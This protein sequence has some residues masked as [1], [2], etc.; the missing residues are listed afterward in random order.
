[1]SDRSGYIT[2]FTNSGAYIKDQDNNYITMP[3]KTYKQV[4]FNNIK[5]INH[6]NNWQYIRKIS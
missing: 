4:N 2:G 6:N 5:V 3:H 1:M